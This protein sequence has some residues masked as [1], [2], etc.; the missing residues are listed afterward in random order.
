M[1]EW[2]A[3][4]DARSA[5]FTELME[6]N[7]MLVLS[8]K[9][10]ES[11]QIGSDITVTLV[12]SRDGKVRLGIVAPRSIPIVRSEIQGPDE[13]ADAAKRNREYIGGDL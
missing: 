5:A 13:V 8:R 7:V 9:R 2:P 3:G 12:D 1:D 10:G 4:H 11:I 6:G